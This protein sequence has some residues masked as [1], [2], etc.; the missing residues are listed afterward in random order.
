MKN[1]FSS[2]AHAFLYSNNSQPF[3]SEETAT[4]KCYE[5]EI[6]LGDAYAIESTATQK[7]HTLPNPL[8]SK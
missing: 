5:L 8:H 6:L 7:K 4:L 3:T 1:N 2:N